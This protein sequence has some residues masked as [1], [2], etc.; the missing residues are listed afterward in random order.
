MQA[1]LEGF[2]FEGLVRLRRRVVARGQAGGNLTLTWMKA[3]VTIE[4][5]SMRRMNALTQAFAR[6]M[7]RSGIF[8]CEGHAAMPSDRRANAVAVNVKRFGTTWQSG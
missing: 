2:F 7:R 4:N 6:R 8:Q 1:G 3:I 5:P